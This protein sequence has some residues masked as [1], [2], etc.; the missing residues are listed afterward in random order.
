[1]T[2]FYHFMPSEAG[3]DE[4][5]RFFDYTRSSGQIGPE[6]ASLGKS[7]NGDFDGIEICVVDADDLLDNPEGIIKAY[8]NSVGLEFHPSMLEW[9]TE[10][11]HQQAV[12]AFEKWKGF[13]ED[14][15]DSS[16]LKPRAHVSIHDCQSSWLNHRTKY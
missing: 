3:Y 6:K 9:K 4:M 10:E 13:H 12:D 15:I 5:R 2:G 11:D 14:A 7:V 1:M 8:C 16:D